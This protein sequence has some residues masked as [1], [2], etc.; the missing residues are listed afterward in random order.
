MTSPWE[1]H[2]AAAC[3]E[4]YEVAASAAEMVLA[5]A[6]STYPWI[7]ATPG[8]VDP[9]GLVRAEAAALDTWVTGRAWPIATIVP[10]G[11]NLS[12][13]RIH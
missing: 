4:L 6:T 7:H 1:Q 8:V 3:G 5:L 13:A 2:S 12:I 9:S 11:V 10:H